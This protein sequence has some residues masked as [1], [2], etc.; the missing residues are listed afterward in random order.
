VGSRGIFTLIAR[1]EGHHTLKYILGLGCD[2]YFSFPSKVHHFNLGDSQK[3]LEAPKH[4][5]GE[6]ISDTMA[7]GPYILAILTPKE[8]KIQDVS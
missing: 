3:Q 1:D 4:W 5:S 2:V 7:E 8:G 6:P